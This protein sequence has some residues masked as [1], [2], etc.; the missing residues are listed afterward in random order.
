MADAKPRRR[1]ERHLTSAQKELSR[2]RSR[3]YYL[4]HKD[5]VLA[6]SKA[7]YSTNVAE[8]RARRRDMYAK[9]QAAKE[10]ENG[11]V[12]PASS[13][14]AKPRAENALSLRFILN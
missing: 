1:R 6:K 10:A 9:K 5:R 7:R 4:K 12:T 13:S 11:V 2:R 14:P 8:E 3:V